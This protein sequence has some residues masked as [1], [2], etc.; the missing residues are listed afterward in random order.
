[1]CDPVTLLATAVAAGS[2]VS[3]YSA[4]RQRK[5]ASQGRTQALEQADATAKAQDQAFNRANQK[6]PAIDLMGAENLLQGGMGGAST[7]LTG[8]S[9]I[10]PAAMLGRK[11]LLGG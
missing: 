9:G 4:E 11:T 1:M 8:P 10:N 2:A 7:L 6:K 5:A 3:V